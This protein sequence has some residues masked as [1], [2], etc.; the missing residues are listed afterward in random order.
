[1][2]NIGSGGSPS[3]GLGE[4]FGPPVIVAVSAV[5]LR[6]LPSQAVFLLMAWLLASCPIGILI[7]HCVLSE[8]R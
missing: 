8:D 3:S 1:M 4:L 2:M 5:M 7:G 6:I